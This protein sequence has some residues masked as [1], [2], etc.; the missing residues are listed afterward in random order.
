MFPNSMI[1]QVFFTIKQSIKVIS[2]SFV[3]IL[4]KPSYEPVANS[5]PSLCQRGKEREEYERV[6]V[7]DSLDTFTD[8]QYQ[9]LQSHSPG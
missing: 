9:N 8:P 1:L 2:P 6:C 3:H 5:V 7:S 4:A